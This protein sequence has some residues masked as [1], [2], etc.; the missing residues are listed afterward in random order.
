MKAATY[1]A[2]GSAEDVLQLADLT[3]PELGPYDVQVSLR[4]SGINPSDVKK[5]AGQR[6]D[7]ND[8]FVVPHSDGAGVITA[9]GSKVDVA[10]VGERV[11]LHSAQHNRP[12]GTAATGVSLPA[13]LANPLADNCSFEQGACIGIPMMTAH[14]CLTVAGN[15]KGQNILVTGAMGRVGFYAV[16]M[17]KLMGA[18]VVATYGA[19]RDEQAVLDLG[20]DYVVSH[21]DDQFP[22]QIMQ[23]L[24]GAHIH[25]VIDVEFGVN[26]EKYTPVLSDY[27]SI[28]SY[29]SGVHPTPAIPFYALMFKNISFHPVFVYAMPDKA[30]G[31]SITDIN[32]WL[33]Q[34]KLTFHDIKTFSLDDIVAAHEYVEQGARGHVVQSI[35]K[36][37][38]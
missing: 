28:A 12:W 35:D 30:I 1:T 25:H 14:R 31:A 3:A 10:R 17:A 27:S 19:D 37:A 2:F 16:Q 29:A 38:A 18:T 26:V 36:T 6:G 13:M 11:W 15:M 21:R 7:F 24:D 9:V 34:G 20:A 8:E 32:R 5:R 22:E 23:Q 4:S 33:Q